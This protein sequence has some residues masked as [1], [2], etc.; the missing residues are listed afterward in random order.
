MGET[1]KFE[2]NPTKQFKVDD[3][4]RDPLL[5]TENPVL[6]G[7][8]GGKYEILGQNYLGSGGE[9]QV[10]GARSLAT[11]EYY[12][13][14]VYDEF[15]NTKSSI[16]N[17]N[18][19]IEF[20]RANSDYK[21]THLMPI[22]DY[23]WITVNLIGEEIPISYPVD[24][25][26]CCE[27]GL[28]QKATYAELKNSIIPQI[29]E[30]IHLMH[31]EHLVHRDIKPGNIYRYNNVVV[32]A[33][34]GTSCDVGKYD[35]YG[36]QK[37]RGTIGYTAPEV[38]QGYVET[39]CDYYSLGCTI[40][41]LY[42][43]EHVYQHLVDQKDMGAINKSINEKGLPLNCPK[44]EE[45][46]QLLVDTLIN[47][48]ASERAGYD[49]IRLWY[50]NYKEFERKFKDQKDK[51]PKKSFEIN[52]FNTI[53]KSEEELSAVMAQNWE[54]A[55][56]DLYR[57]RFNILPSFYSSYDAT[58]GNAIGDVIEAKETAQNQDLGLAKILHIINPKGPLYWK[59]V[60]FRKST[61]ISV[62]IA[63]KAVSKDDIISMLMSGYVSWKLENTDG[64]A[65]SEIHKVKN[66]EIIAAQEKD[67]AYYYA[68]YVFSPADEQQDYLGLKT[69]DDIFAY[70]TKDP[71]DFNQR[72]M[73]YMNDM[74][75]AY[76]AFRD[77]KD[78]VLHFKNLM[79]NSDE[80]KNA[81]L[82]YALFGQLC[83]N[84]IAVQACYINY[85][86]YS[87][88]TW[89]RKNLDLYC[90]N[91]SAAEVIRT[92][93]LN[94]Q[95]SSSE[96]IKNLTKEFIYMED[97]MKQFMKLF[98]NNVLLAY[99]G[100]G[101][102]KETNGITS[103]NSDAYFLEEYCGMLVPVGYIRYLTAKK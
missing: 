51:R 45:D 63:N 28:I 68:K 100:V 71:M 84:K 101:N 7:K 39:A 98:H 13:A 3:S 24:I 36:T 92:R 4:D 88:L 76:I 79:S 73:H 48:K 70:V 67:L 8:C 103:H 61:E 44:N 78:T 15:K 89:L 58:K 41:T 18:R 37:R 16:N 59:G 31:E 81:Q 20:I 65:E 62:A 43:G 40:A 102:D 2:R 14:K 33:D 87:Y 52:Y 57:D 99:M 12:V 80:K 26:P 27:N 5:M 30:A 34:F 1:V 86:P 55:K 32:I 23:G 6:C 96:N 95:L 35:I 17:R 60:T 69:I 42:K 29:V 85:G 10:F 90:F 25:I 47:M 66:I 97:I 9:S 91:S 22:L 77:N 54:Y 38:N 64:V 46:L 72:C 75:L 50:S 19:V 82:S 83:Q 74:M 93:I 56:R 11:D 49:D 94:T 53:C 21:K